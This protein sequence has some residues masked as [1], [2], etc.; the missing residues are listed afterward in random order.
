MVL[1]G[2]TR[3]EIAVA[4]GWPLST[5]KSRVNGLLWQARC[6]AELIPVAPG[7]VPMNYR[8][9]TLDPRDCKACGTEFVP[10]RAD[11]LFCGHTCRDAFHH[12]GRP[13][14]GATPRECAECGG[15]FKP[16]RR[17]DARFCS[18]HCQQANRRARRAAERG[19]AVA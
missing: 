8:R 13:C 17:G 9:F 6:K 14:G 10:W 1:D 7:H 11:Q 16:K 2:A 4:L 5:S 15:T 18:Y 19:R 12:R 3:R